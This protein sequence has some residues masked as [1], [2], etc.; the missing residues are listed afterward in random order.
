MPA[1]MKSSSTSALQRSECQVLSEHGSNLL[2][3][4][5]RK[6]LLCLQAAKV[7]M[8]AVIVHAACT[9]ASNLPSNV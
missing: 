1:P 6:Y 9:A 3:V 5:L 2:Q 8:S 7:L 4:D